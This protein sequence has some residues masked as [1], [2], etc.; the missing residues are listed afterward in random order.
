MFKSVRRRRARRPEADRRVV[1]P[2]CDRRKVCAAYNTPWCTLPGPISS[3]LHA[4][5]SGIGLGVGGVRN[6]Y[7]EEEQ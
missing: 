5:F 3:K 2:A 7:C 1:F 6:E 4:V